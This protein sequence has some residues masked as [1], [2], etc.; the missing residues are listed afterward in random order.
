MSMT[1]G[2]SFYDKNKALFA[3][4]ATCVAS[5]NTA[6]Q[7]L[8]LGTNKYFR[9]QSSG[10]NDATTETLTITLPVAT[11][12]SRIFLVGMNF[13]AF[14]IQY[15]NGSP[16]DF[17]GVTGLDSYSDS[18]I[19]VTLFDRTTAYFQ[20]DSVTTDTIIITVDT[21]Q[22]VNAEKYLNQ[23]IATNELGTLVGFPGMSGIGLDRNDRSEKSIT[24]RYHIEKSYESTEFD[25]SLKTYPVQADIDLLD[26]LH[27]R[28]DPFLV[29][30]CGGKPD[31]FTYTQRGFRVQDVYQMKVDRGLKNGYYQNIYV[32][33]VNQAYSFKE[34]V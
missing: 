9:W 20:F 5:S 23:F 4:G 16:A 11:A 19:D 12:I 8:I 34:V 27:D 22:T 31:Q 3:D 33:G 32:A 14:Q 6:D 29:W 1:G 7:N 18:E 2:I 15:D 26:D 25:L 30:L 21:T 17:T 10:S 28:E 24:G 13:K